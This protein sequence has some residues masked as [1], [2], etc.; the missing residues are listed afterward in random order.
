[1]PGSALCPDQPRARIS[2]VP[3]SACPD[4][5]CAPLNTIARLDSRTLTHDNYT[6]MAPIDEAVKDLKSREEGEQFFLREITN[7]YSM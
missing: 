3:G 2:L 5:P 1:M 4:Q 7:K 6:P